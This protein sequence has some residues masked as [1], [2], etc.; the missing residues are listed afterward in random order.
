MTKRKGQVIITT[1]LILA[2]L[3]LIISTSL[4]FTSM[5]YQKLYYDDTK[6]V[7]DN[8]NQDLNRVLQR[9][10]VYSSKQYL[11]GSTSMDKLQ[12]KAHDNLT[13]WLQ[14]ILV[15][16]STKGIQINVA[17]ENMLA[18]EWSN[19]VGISKI[20]VSIRLNLTYLNFY[21]WEKNYIQYL[22]ISDINITPDRKYI[23]FKLTREGETPE[24]KL[25][26]CLLY[27]DDL[28]IEDFT[29]SSTDVGYYTINLTKNPL[30][31][32]I[33]SYV[34]KV[35]IIVNNSRGIYVGAL[36]DAISYVLLM[37]RPAFFYSD[38][39]T[40]PNNITLNGIRWEENILVR[41]PQ[42]QSGYAIINK[43]LREKPNAT[44]LWFVQKINFN[45]ATA[46]NNITAY[47]KQGN[48][49]ER[50]TYRLQIDKNGLYIYKNNEL[51][52][53]A[54][55]SSL[56][57]KWLTLVFFIDE[58]SYK[59][60][61]YNLLNLTIYDSVSG[62]LIKSIS[63]LDQINNLGKR[64]DLSLSFGYKIS[65]DSPNIRIDDLIISESVRTGYYPL[66][67]TFIGTTG[68][69]ESYKVKISGKYNDTQDVNIEVPFKIVQGAPIA[70][71]NLAKYPII[72]DVKIDVYYKDELV[73]LASG[74]FDYIV[75]GDYYYFGY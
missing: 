42:N 70:T 43:N 35:K 75:A 53:S 7:I 11:K 68:M 21:N 73:P 48:K 59:G 57:N 46:F 14:S 39:K 31:S 58:F 3:M 61:D 2:I 74:S 41:N 52:N 13:Y 47:Y 71:V 63:F 28:K 26:T 55:D 17:E 56:S 62:S 15:T 30:P 51:K 29:I 45:S 60:K 23:N 50:I 9:I 16:Y 1:A 37:E 20:Q 6:E 34:P 69:N 5:T 54:A 49:V 10:L 22:K 27:V 18:L 25:D 36:Y 24:D 12:N 66:N 32:P 8:I 64:T 65:Q 40:Y 38:F 44:R 4:H 72:R 67:I 33:G 19:N